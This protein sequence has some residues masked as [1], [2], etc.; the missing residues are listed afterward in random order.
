LINSLN[1]GEVTVAR[2]QAKHKDMQHILASM[3]S[4]GNI[5]LTR[6]GEAILFGTFRFFIGSDNLHTLNQDEFD[7]VGRL[8]D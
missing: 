8:S 2:N 6:R 5:F 7:I 4:S 1:F 3:M